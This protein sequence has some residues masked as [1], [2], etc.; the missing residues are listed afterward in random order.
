[1]LIVATC[2]PIGVWAYTYTCTYICVYTRCT[3][4][5]W[6]L[7]PC[8]AR[9]ICLVNSVMKWVFR[10]DGSPIV[11]TISRASIYNAV[12]CT[13]SLSGILVSITSLGIVF[14]IKSF[15][16]WQALQPIYAGRRLLF[17]NSVVKPTQRSSIFTARRHS[18]QIVVR[19]SSPTL[20]SAKNWI[21]I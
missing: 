9:A 11:I 21:Y 19:R 4:V 18:T 3:R 6:R 13:L 14:S 2:L 16:K 12:H 8:I 20:K 10:L 5:F 1:M 15:T 17:T 7:T